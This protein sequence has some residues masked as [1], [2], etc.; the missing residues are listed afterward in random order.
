[1]PPVKFVAAALATGALVGSGSAA[2][3]TCA[4][5]TAGYLGGL[6][7]TSVV[8]TVG[9]F[10]MTNTA[11]GID[12]TSAVLP[13]ANG[14]SGSA[15]LT[16]G[17]L[18]AYSSNSFASAAEWD[19]F[20]FS[21]LPAGGATVTATLGLA[22]STLTGLGV[23]LAT[24]FAGAA[25]AG[26][27]DDASFQTAFGNAATGLGL[28]ASISVSFLADNVTPIAVVA[29][30][31]A[32]GA[33]A[34]LADP[35]TLTLTLPPGATGVSASGVFEGFGPSRSVPEPGSL[36]I[37]IAGLGL[38]GYARRAAAVQTD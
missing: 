30:I 14:M 23:G 16:S 15:D 35:P 26:F 1:M 2:H 25:G 20:T 36:V 17:I 37:L 31:E 12:V 6:F 29:E 21:G 18:T 32:D 33:I 5:P 9:C 19:T 22:G 4:I 28:P 24:L 10:T 13:L 3:A 38:L 11:G 7:G 8:T 27:P 34:D